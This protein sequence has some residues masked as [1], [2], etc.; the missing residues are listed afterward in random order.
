MPFTHILDLRVAQDF[1]V[2]FGGKRIQFQITYDIFN[3]T[4][5]LN[6]DWGRTYFI[7]NDNLQLIRFNGYKNATTDLTPTYSFNPTL[8]QPQTV[9]N[10]STTTIPSVSPRWSSQLGLRINF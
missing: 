1:N 6:R 2:K 4:N 8:A 3:F 5:F 9:A 7:T 10:V